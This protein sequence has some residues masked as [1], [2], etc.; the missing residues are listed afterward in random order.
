MSLTKFKSTSHDLNDKDIGCLKSL[1]PTDPE[2]EKT[3]IMDTKG[4]LL[5]DVYRWILE[6]PAFRR[7]RDDQ[8]ARLLWIRGDPGKGKTMLA[9]GIIDKLKKLIGC[10]KL[11]SFFF[12]QAADS[13]INNAT[14]VLRCLVRQLIDQ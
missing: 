6:D 13:R 12:C 3:R 4:G 8:K 1:W 7:W 5:N 10:S 11:L 9:C 2:N 14:A